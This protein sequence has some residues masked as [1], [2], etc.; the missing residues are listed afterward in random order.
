MKEVSEMT[1]LTRALSRFA[2]ELTFEK[3]PEE[4]IEMTR[5]YIVDYLASESAGWKINRTF[6]EAVLPL[7]EGLGNKEES[8]ILYLSHKTPAENAAFMNAVYA[9]GADM[10]DGNK[11]AMGHV[12]AHVMSAVFALAQSL[13]GVCWKDVFV[14]INVGYDV[15]NRVAAAAQPGLVHR[16]FHSTGT[17]GAIACAAASAKLLG[18][19]EE[20]IYSAMA[21]AAIQASGLI[22]IAES[23]QNCK[24]LN[25]ANAART[26]IFSA[27]L[28]KAGIKGPVHP[29]ES[30]KGWMHA[31]TD[32][33]HEDMITEGLGETFTIMES[34]LKPYP[35]CRH[36][37]CGIE[38]AM[39]D[40]KRMLETYG[41]IDPDSIQ[42]VRVDIYRNAIQIAGQIEIPQTVDDA[43]F[44]IH[45]SLATALFRGHFNLEDLEIDEMGEEIPEIIGKIRL[46]EDPSMENV[47]A[48][49]RGARV[50]VIMNDGQSFSE[51]VLVPKGDAGNTLSWPELEE[52]LSSGLVQTPGEG[53]AGQILEAVRTV[54]P[55]QPY[56]SIYAFN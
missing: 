13:E 7:M 30:T 20:G 23:G 43:K 26:G 45:Y 56:T 39:T 29:L 1:D 11:K 46:I 53:K 33:V 15:Y 28:A 38:G 21:I 5:V 9:H 52:K 12:A 44:S 50:T 14:A 10:D 16:G 34:Y 36:T 8:D 32:E 31:M 40:R 42:E 2:A 22:I 3:L 27:K 19:D 25:P 51:T 6:N 49:I 18:L 24:P 55:E 54:D 35:S 48:G 4:V 17:A 41:R 47:R 37:H